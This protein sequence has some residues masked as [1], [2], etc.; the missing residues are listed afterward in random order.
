MRQTKGGVWPNCRTGHHI[1]STYRTPA[2][3]DGP[4]EY[5]TDCDLCGES[6][7]DSPSGFI[8]FVQVSEDLLFRQALGQFARRIY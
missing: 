3:V 2:S 4:A 6:F 5:E 8:P 7:S 1:W